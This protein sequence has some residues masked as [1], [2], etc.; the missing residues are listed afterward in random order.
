MSRIEALFRY[1][2]F[3]VGSLSMAQDPPLVAFDVASVKRAAPLTTAA[4]DSGPSANLRLVRFRHKTIL[5]LMMRAWQAKS[6]QIIG[7]RLIETE[8][9]DIIAKVPDSADLKLVPIMLRTLLQERF[10]LK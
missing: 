9:Y 7:P 5:S 3:A 8:H 2:L 6:Y 10:H 4:T 1:T